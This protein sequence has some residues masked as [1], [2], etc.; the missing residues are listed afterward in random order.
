MSFEKITDALTREWDELSDTSNAPLWVR[1]GW[2]EP[3][4]RAFGKGE[5]E[6]FTLRNGGRLRAA[7]PIGRSPTMARSPSNWHTPTFGAIAVDE[8]ARRLLLGELLATKIPAFTFMFVEEDGPDET[9]LAFAAAAVRRRVLTRAL[10]SSPVVTLTG[11]WDAYEAAL[12]KKVRTELR[13]RRRRLSE[14]GRLEFTVSDGSRDLAQSLDEG[15]EVER[16]GWKGRRGTAIASSPSTRAFYA[17]VAQW[18]AARGWL[19]LGFL[20]LD[21]KALAFDFCIE[22]GGSHFLLKTGFDPDFNKYGPGMLLRYEMIKRAFSEENLQSY[23][24]LGQSDPWKMQWTDQVRRRLAVQ[25]F[26]RLTGIGHWTAYRFGRPLAKKAI[27][28]ARR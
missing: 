9:A 20:R 25:A 1:P 10:E 11:E 15:F 24:F 16:A 12:S 23:E 28:M 2:I 4:W 14:M 8:P 6:L 19:A 18:S 7:I 27:A 22:H 26:D 3:W 21:G 17:E 5:F 13:R